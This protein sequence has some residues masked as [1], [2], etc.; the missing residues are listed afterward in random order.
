MQHLKEIKDPVMEDILQETEQTLTKAGM[1]MP[2]NL[3]YAADS[4]DDILLHQLLKRGSNPNEVDGNV[5]KTALVNKSYHY[6]CLS[7]LLTMNRNGVVQLT[8]HFS[9][10]AYCS[11]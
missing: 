4:G 9:L 1:E 8:W 3:C 5:G 7:W 2:L 6:S 11:S 10:S